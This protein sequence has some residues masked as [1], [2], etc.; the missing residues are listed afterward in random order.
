MI[1]STEYFQQMINRNENRLLDALE[2]FEYLFPEYIWSNT[3]KGI[4]I[5]SKYD[6]FLHY[7]QQHDLS[8][9]FPEYKGGSDPKLMMDFIVNQFKIKTPKNKKISV[10]VGDLTDVDQFQIMFKDI[11]KIVNDTL[12]VDDYIIYETKE[13]WFLDET[14][15]LMDRLKPYSK[16]LKLHKLKI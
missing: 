13:K 7:Y 3:D 10:L 15:N 6:L 2:Y 14:W 16:C 12:V 9:V 1:G 8:K 11:E 5:L 4:L